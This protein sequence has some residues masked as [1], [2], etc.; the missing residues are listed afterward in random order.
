MI[1]LKKDFESIKYCHLT[2]QK[3]FVEFLLTEMTNPDYDSLDNEVISKKLNFINELIPL[4][5]EIINQKFKSI[6]KIESLFYQYYNTTSV[7][8]TIIE[9]TFVNTFSKFSKI[10]I[11]WD[12]ELDIEPIERYI[13]IVDKIPFTFPSNNDSLKRERYSN[14]SDNIFNGLSQEYNSLILERDNPNILSVGISN[15][16]ANINLPKVY[17]II[18]D[19]RDLSKFIEQKT[20]VKCAYNYR[21]LFHMDLWRGHHSHCLIEVIGDIP[22]IFDE[23]PQNGTKEHKGIGLCTKYD[24]EFIKERNQSLLFF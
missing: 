8:K 4:Y 24:W 22:E 3:K 23:L 18:F 19:T 9:S 14:T 7:F 21:V 12:Y 11:S 6:E 16:Y 13:R 5:F 20:I 15:S 10:A 17:D 1:P 2:I